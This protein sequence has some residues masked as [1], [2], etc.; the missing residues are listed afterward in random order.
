MNCARGP[1]GHGR[2]PQ[3]RHAMAADFALPVHGRDVAKRTLATDR[4]KPGSKMPGCDVIADFGEWYERKQQCH[5][6]MAKFALDKCEETFRSCEW[7]SF[8]YWYKFHLRERGKP[9]TLEAT[10]PHRS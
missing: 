1:A 10:G 6:P 3:L 4:V 8:G 2:S 5:A 9:R 7:S